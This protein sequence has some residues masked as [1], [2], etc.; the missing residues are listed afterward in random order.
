MWD[1]GGEAVA[2]GCARVTLVTDC[3]DTNLL[4]RPVNTRSVQID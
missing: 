3:S 1:K 2:S 4:Q